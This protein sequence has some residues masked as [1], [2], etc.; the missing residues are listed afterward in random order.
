MRSEPTKRSFSSRALPGASALLLFACGMV[1]ARASVAQGIDE[2]LVEHGIALRRERR[3]AEALEQF[4]KAFQL[5]PSPRTRAQIALAEQALG[6]WADAE[7]D[8]VAAL[9]AVDDA[10][11]AKN[12]AALQQGLATIRSH[13][14]SLEVQSNVPGAELLV[15]GIRIGE[16]PMPPFRVAIGANDVEVRAPHW[17]PSRRQISVE[18]EIATRVTVDLAAMEPTVAAQTTSTAPREPVAAKPPTSEPGGRPN[19]LGGWI[20]LAGAGVLLAGG[21]AAHAAR[22]SF[23]NSTTTTRCVL[24][25]HPLNRAMVVAAATERTAR[26]RSSSR[27]SAMAGRPS[28]QAWRSSC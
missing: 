20:S 3:D 1:Y 11:I 27:S 26:L 23:A 13:V 7:R 18:A 15:N 4:R 2:S 16:L 8:L 14:G 10:W 24:H 9:S 17:R 5:H 25:E 28:Q 22:E 12:G 19:R 21:I 6:Q